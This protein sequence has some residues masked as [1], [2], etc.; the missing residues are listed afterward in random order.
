VFKK[1]GDTANMNLVEAKRKELNAE[2]ARIAKVRGEAEA[3]EAKA[4]LGK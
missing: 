2:A 4:V 1:A 3:A